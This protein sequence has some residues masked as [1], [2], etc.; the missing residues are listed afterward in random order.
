MRR[1]PSILATA[2]VVTAATASAQQFNRDVAALAAPNIWTDGAE[3]ADVDGDGDLDLLFANGSSYGGTGG[4][5]SQLTV[6]AR[7][8]ETRTDR[9]YQ[10]CATFFMAFVRGPFLCWRF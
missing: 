7:Y 5:D 2:A 1:I 3:L 9:R 8:S 4:Q 6:F 10:S